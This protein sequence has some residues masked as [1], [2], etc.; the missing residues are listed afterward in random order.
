MKKTLIA[1]LL[2]VAMVGAAGVYRLYR[3]AGVKSAQPCWGE[4]RLI[5]A[6]KEQWALETHAAPGSPVTVSNILPY[7]SAV[8]TCHIAGAAYI[9]GK[10]G[11]EPRCTVHGTLSNFK[12]DRY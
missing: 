6:A 1:V 12:P 5:Q 8:P 9:L 3:G 2:V 11:E 7:L 10:V 4:L